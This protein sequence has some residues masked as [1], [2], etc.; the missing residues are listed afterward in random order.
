MEEELKKNFNDA[1][2]VELALIVGLWNM[3]N[4][5]F[6]TLRVDPETFV[7]PAHTELMYS[8]FGKQGK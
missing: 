2:R 3:T 5:I 8:T 1:E 4:R 7:D 6:N